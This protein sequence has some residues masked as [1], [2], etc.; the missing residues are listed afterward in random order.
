MILSYCKEKDKKRKR[1]AADTYYKPAACILYGSAAE[2]VD[3]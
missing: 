2:S 1:Y 3:I